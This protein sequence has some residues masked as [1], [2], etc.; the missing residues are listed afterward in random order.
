MNFNIEGDRQMNLTRGDIVLIDLGL[1]EQRDSSSVQKGIRPAVIVQNNKANKHAP[2]VTIVPMTSKVKGELP[3]HVKI[4]KQE[5]VEKDS[6]A[7][8][9]N[10]TSISKEKI[11]KKMGKLGYQTMRQIEIAIMMQLGLMSVKRGKKKLA[12][13]EERLDNTFEKVWQ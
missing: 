11:I 4:M 10:I 13:M 8:V 5:G 2:I 6:V 3:T 7:L 12:E 9:E 1:S